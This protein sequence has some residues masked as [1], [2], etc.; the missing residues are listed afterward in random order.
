MTTTANNPFLKS[1]EKNSLLSVT[2]TPE[3]RS[4]LEALGAH[5]GIRTNSGVAL[6]ALAEMYEKYKR[7]M[8]A[9]TPPAG[10]AVPVVK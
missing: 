3:Q 5:L 10:E 2:L 6:Q 4:V 1:T 7:Q 9:D 8:A